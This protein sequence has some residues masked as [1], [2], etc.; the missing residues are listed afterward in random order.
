MR[1]P[2]ADL[3]VALRVAITS[4]INFMKGKPMKVRVAIIEQ[5]MAKSDG[6]LSFGETVRLVLED[7]G[8]PYFWPSNGRKYVVV[9]NAPLYGQPY[10][11]P[12]FPMTADQILADNMD[13][14][15]VAGAEGNRLKVFELNDSNA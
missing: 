4:T 12:R 14:V 9:T 11:H 2:T 1:N 8:L 5:Q 3:G 6:W 10:S 13:K 7:G 15:T